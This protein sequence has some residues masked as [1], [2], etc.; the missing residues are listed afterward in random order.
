MNFTNT[1]QNNRMGDF[2][3]SDWSEF[4]AGSA[5]AKVVEE[6]VKYRRRKLE[7]T[8]NMADN[9]RDIADI[10]RIMES[11]V[12][13]TSYNRFLLCL[14]EDSAG[15]LAAG[16]NL[17]ITAQYEKIN[18]SEDERLEHISDQIHRWKADVNYYDLYSEILTKGMVQLKYDTMPSS[19]LKDIY[20]SQNVKSARVYHLMTTKDSAKVFF[21]SVAST[22]K[23]EPSASDRVII[24]SA[25]D[26]LINIFQ[27]HRK[28]Y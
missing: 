12:E 21:C 19:K 14:G 25:V 10:H 13:E 26:K 2:S 5:V 3:W 9:A 16:K 11:V 8:V 7:S 4:L 22:L 20:T 1:L 15:V 17:Y 6:V 18:R 24:D 23:D 28:F 27:K